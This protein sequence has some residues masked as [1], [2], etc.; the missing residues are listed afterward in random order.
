MSNE[1]PVTV[2]DMMKLAKKLRLKMY[3]D[4]GD[5]GDVYGDDGH[6]AAV[7][8]GHSSALTTVAESIDDTFQF[9]SS[10]TQDDLDSWR[11]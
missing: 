11:K 10:L 4:V 8:E 2:A 6:S 3:Y 9:D 1:R 7:R 5:V